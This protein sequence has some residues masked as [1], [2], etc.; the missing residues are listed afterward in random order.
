MTDKKYGRLINQF[1]RM[2]VFDNKH[3]K[4]VKM[5][6]DIVNNNFTTL[7]ENLNSY[8]KQLSESMVQL[9]NL[10]IDSATMLKSHINILGAKILNQVSNVSN[11]VNN[12][13]SDMEYSIDYVADKIDR[14]R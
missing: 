11:S 3:Q 5:K 9:A 8:N 4:D 12:K 1:D 2:S 10:T 13:L 7:I 14:K 6:L